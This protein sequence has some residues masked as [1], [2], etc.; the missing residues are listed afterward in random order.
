MKKYAAIIDYQGVAYSGWQI[1]KDANSIQ[2]NI[3]SA[4]SKVANQPISSICAG[5]TDAGVHARSQVIHFESNV[6][7]TSYAWR[8]G[9]N[10]QLPKDIRVLWCDQVDD[11]FNAR[12]SATTRS[13]Q[14]IINQ[15]D[16]DSAA[17]ENRVYWYPHKLDVIKMHESAQYLLGKQDFTSFRAAHCQS[18]SPIRC[19]ES[20][21]V[22]GHGDYVIIDI[23]ANAFLYHMV[24]N[25]T[26]SLIEVG[27]QKRPVEWIESVLAEK[28]RSKA[29][30]TAPAHGLYFVSVDYPKRFNIPIQQS[31]FLM[32]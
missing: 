12:F 13:Y 17:F 1:Q 28:N 27:Q 32:L 24:R 6:S 2:Q 4:F 7:R 23:K 11:E 20:V 9:C 3:E 25:I 19:I 30:V 31:P 14:Y 10:T 21:S 18:N 15:S 26:G 29:G 5:R 22:S 16:F 8:M